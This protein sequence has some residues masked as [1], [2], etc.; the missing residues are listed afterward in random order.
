MRQFE[1]YITEVET[2]ALSKSL[3]VGNERSRHIARIGK[4]L[5][6]V[7]RKLGGEDAQNTENI[8][9]LNEFSHPSSR[10]I[11]RPDPEALGSPGEEETEHEEE[12][13]ELDVIEEKDAEHRLAAAEWALERESE[14]AR[15]Q[16]ENEELRRLLAG[17][18]SLK[19]DPP[20]Q[21]AS[22]F[23]VIPG[24][25]ANNGESA[26]SDVTSETSSRSLSP[27]SIRSL[28][29]QIRPLGGPAGTVGPY[30]TLKKSKTP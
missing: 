25:D 4:L 26:T 23:P 1:S 13:E 7:M 20:P 22:V 10:I 27:S 18:E 11:D 12:E 19:P 30:G 6:E 16:R 2:E 14:L 9:T 17:V 21:P 24:E 15:L 28:Q 3:I 29:M 8:D 5:R